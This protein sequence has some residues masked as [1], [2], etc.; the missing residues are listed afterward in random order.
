MK[1]YF[2]MAAVATMFAACTN[3]DVTPQVDA[4]TGVP[5][6]VKT[7]IAKPVDSRA[8]T[9]RDSE[10]DIENFILSIQSM[11]EGDTDYFVLMEQNEGSWTSSTIGDDGQTLEACNM[12]WANGNNVDVSALAMGSGTAKTTYR[13][14]TIALPFSADQS[15]PDAFKANDYLC[16]DLKE[17]APS[18][19][20]ITVNFEHL[21]SKVT[22][23]IVA[24]GN[25]ADVQ[26]EGTT[27]VAS[28]SLSA[29]TF[30]TEASDAIIKAC[31]DE[32]ADGD[33]KMVYE[34]ILIPQEVAAGK[35]AVSFRINDVTYKWTSADAVDFVSGWQYTIELT[36][37]GLEGEAL[38]VKSIEVR[39]WENDD[40]V[41]MGG[42]A[43]Q[44]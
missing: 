3:E 11:N 12:V 9:G 13:G 2:A 43:I 29:C 24:G 37:K 26:V 23:A 10:E 40:D 16:M 28:Y 33:G 44:Q 22:I 6:V 30:T 25:V 4:M 1:K 5:I 21:M 7:N 36:P 32:D 34:A 19:S 20:G 8:I 14:G 42:D 27:D 31:H 35:F 41:T 15:T 38:L 39:G 17:V 18:A